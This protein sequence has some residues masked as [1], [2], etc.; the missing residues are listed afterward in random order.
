MN[1]ITELSNAIASLVESAGGSL[2]HVDAGRW[3]GSSGMV[4]SSDG[5]IITAAHTLKRS[6][7]QVTLPGGRQV[8]ATL[9]GR[10][11]STDIALLKADVDGLSVP[12]W[13]E[14]QGLKV[15]Q[16]VLALGW[17]GKAV[18]ASLG[19][20]SNLGG[21]WRTPMGGKLERY[22]QPDVSVY[23]G[24]SG[25]A[26]VDAEGRVLGMNTQALRRGMTLTLAMPTLK[27][28][29]E[30][31]QKHGSVRRGY[32][33]VS[34]QPVRLPEGAG[35]EVGLLLASVE[36]GSPAAKGGLMLGDVILS[37]NGKA[38]GRP[39]DLLSA[40]SELQAGSPVSLKVWRGGQTHEF[41]VTLGERQ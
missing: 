8:S 28:V 15:G 13:A 39:H 20:L 32:L 24:F 10:D 11:P 9:R 26:L 22:I 35:Q 12:S 23:P 41:S 37:L 36:P 27:R 5:H 14:P 7:V 31:L 38:L 34:A 17:P 40:L 3:T 2:V 21:E 18:R 25:G 29:V 30:A 6:D 1:P 19:I 4:W 16:V 33:G